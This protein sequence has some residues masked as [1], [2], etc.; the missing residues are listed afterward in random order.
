MNIIKQIADKIEGAGCNPGDTDYIKLANEIYYDVLTSRST[1]PS[2][3]S[4]SPRLHS[5]EPSWH[6]RMNI[7]GCEDHSYVERTAQL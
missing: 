4:P 1:S 7:E 3:H 5:P 6:H 2:P